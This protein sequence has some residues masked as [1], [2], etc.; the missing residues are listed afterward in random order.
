MA[1]IELLALVFIAIILFVIT[2]PFI[3]LLVSIEAFIFPEF[4]DG[5]QVRSFITTQSVKQLPEYLKDFVFDPDGWHLARCGRTFNLSELNEEDDYNKIF[6]KD[7]WIKEDLSQRKIKKGAK[8]L[9]QHLI[10]SFSL[11]YKNYQR[12]IR[13]K[14]DFKAIYGFLLSKMGV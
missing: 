11:K 4:F 13:R 9:E 6:Y 5:V 14:L 7:R 10:V 1:I 12:K 8:P 2:P 3:N